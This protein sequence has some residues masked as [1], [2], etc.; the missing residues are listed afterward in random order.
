MNKKGIQLQVHYIPV[1]LQP[2]Y[3]KNYGFKTGDFPIAEE[4]YTREISLPIY[5]SLS[6]DDVRF[7]ADSLKA[8]IN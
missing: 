3:R 8:S 1:H 2:Y 6:N 7:I 4:F 5:Y